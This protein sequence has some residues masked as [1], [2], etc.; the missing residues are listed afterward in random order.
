MELTCQYNWSVYLRWLQKNM[1]TVLTYLYHF[2]KM[3]QMSEWFFALLR[4]VTTPHH[5]SKHP[6]TVR[7]IG[8]LELFW[9]LLHQHTTK[10]T[11]PV[12]VAG[13]FCQLPFSITLMSLACLYS[14]LTNSLPYPLSFLLLSV[15]SVVSCCLQQTPAHFQLCVQNDNELRQ[16]PDCLS[17]LSQTF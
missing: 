15:G 10:P 13:S 7:P 5:L 1:A 8:I 11:S 12:L 16:Q 17:F 14:L 6:D 3:Q 2:S 9:V 4:H